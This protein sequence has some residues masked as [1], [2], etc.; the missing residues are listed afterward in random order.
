MGRDSAFRL[1]TRNIDA[2]SA[3][4]RDSVFWDR[5]LPGFGIRVYRTGRKVYIVQARGPAG[6]RRT[7]VGDHTKL[8]PEA[9]RQRAVQMIDRIKRGE[10]PVPARPVTEPAVADLARRYMEA[11]VE[12]NCRPSTVYAFRRIVSRYVLPELGALRVSAVNRA[13]ISALHHNMRDTPYEAN[14]TLNVISKMFR[15]AEAWELIPS[16]RNPCRTVRRYKDHRRERFLTPEEYRRLGCALDEAE[17]DGSIAPPA[18]AAIRLLLLTGCRKNEILTLRWDDVDRTVGELRLRESKTGMRHVPLTPAVE[19][20][21][22]G[23]ARIEGNPW[24]ITG[25]K[26]GAHLSNVDEPWRRVR[27]RAGLEGVR[28]HDCRH[29]YA[30]RAL[31][32]G[33]GLPMIG[34]LLGHRKVKTTARYAHLARDTEKASAAK[35]GTS[36]AADLLNGK[37]PGERITRQ[38]ARDGE[39]RNEDDFTAHGG[40]AEGR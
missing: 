14:K 30:S 33:E 18:A 26:P 29:S 40:G 35:V 36:I 1:T 28:V 10:E 20:V 6:S 34:R 22:G 3:T 5:D 23:I 25:K 7:V 31:V 24:V 9:A 17:V 15:L 12:V 13:H 16:G 27:A 11:H 37:R 19:R 39:T 8:R 4:G 38:E 2:L 32:L 21:L